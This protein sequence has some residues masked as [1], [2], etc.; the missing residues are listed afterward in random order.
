MTI[1]WRAW[2]IPLVL[3]ASASWPAAIRAAPMFDRGKP[4]SA[5]ERMICADDT[6]ADL[7]RDQAAAFE[8]LRRAASPE[9]RERLLARQRAFL[10]SRGKCF[11]NALNVTPLLQQSCLTD[12]YAEGL[13]T[14]TRSARLADGLMLEQRVTTR[15][16]PRWRVT[17]TDSHPW[18]TG[19]PAAQV[20]AFNRYVAKRLN[21][22]QGMFAAAPIKLD[23]LPDGETNYTREPKK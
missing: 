19:K 6:L 21:L 15:R 22:A 9:G 11:A 7:D 14:L 13:A 12:A 23:P 3:T 5:V 20:E 2:M 17:E 1:A 16:L 4:R 8:R 10:A 18:L